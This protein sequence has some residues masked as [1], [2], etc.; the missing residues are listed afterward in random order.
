[1]AGLCAYIYEGMPV[2]KAASMSYG[3]FYHV[4]VTFDNEDGYMVEAFDHD[5]KQQHMAVILKW[6]PEGSHTGSLRLLTAVLKDQGKAVVMGGGCMHACAFGLAWLMLHRG[7]TDLQIVSW[8]REHDEW[9]KVAWLVTAAYRKML[10]VRSCAASFAV[11]ARRYRAA[12]VIADAWKAVF[13]NPY[14]R[15]GRQQVLMDYHELCS[16][17]AAR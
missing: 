2:T 17:I 9:P 12:H 5:A 1:M 6:W 11:C 16:A 8:L 4:D 14:T 10:F 15:I 3:R 13:R 7:C